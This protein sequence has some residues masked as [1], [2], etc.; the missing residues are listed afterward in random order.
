[1]ES[2]EHTLALSRPIIGVLATLIVLVFAAKRVVWLTKLISSGQK[3]GDE[4]GRKDHLVRLSL[5]QQPTSG[6]LPAAAGGGKSRACGEALP[7][8][9]S[10][11]PGHST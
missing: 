8:L 4:R 7:N 5:R 9:P 3:V 2:L 6:L 10:L 11:A 1:V